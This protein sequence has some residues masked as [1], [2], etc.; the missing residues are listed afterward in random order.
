[1]VCDSD[2][3][4]YTIKNIQWTFDWSRLNPVSGPYFNTTGGKFTVVLMAW[5]VDMY[6]YFTGQDRYFLLASYLSSASFSAK[7]S[8][9]GNAMLMFP[10]S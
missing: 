9:T 5:Q 6:V 3:N 2:V 10:K 8:I 4:K 1:M 7:L